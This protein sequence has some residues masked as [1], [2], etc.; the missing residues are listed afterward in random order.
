[1]WRIIGNISKPATPLIKNIQNNYDFQ[2]LF[3]LRPICKGFKRT[4]TINKNALLVILPPYRHAIPL[5]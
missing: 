5:K 1:M 3:S 2:S 4:L